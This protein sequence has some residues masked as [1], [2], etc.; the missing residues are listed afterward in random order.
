MLILLSPSKTQ[1]PPVESSIAS[2][3]TPLF[4]KR[5]WRIIRSLRGMEEEDV[6]DMLKVSDSLFDTHLTR[7][8]H[9]NKAHTINNAYPAIE[10]FRGHVYTEFED[11]TYTK[12]QQVYMQK[13]LAILSGLYGIIRPCDL[14]QP[15]RLEMASK[16]QVGKDKNLYHFWSEPVSE[17][18]AST[19]PSFILNCASEE[20]TKVIDREVVDAPWID[21]VF[22]EKEGKGFRQITI[23]TK[24]A[25][26]RLAKWMVDNNITTKEGI[27]SF[28]EDGY[29]F[30]KSHS[31]EHTFT[32][33]R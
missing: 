14:V 9:W 18:I 1:E 26:G 25:R 29:T 8:K 22:L 27:T 19:N 12:K 15:Y 11:A 23:Y 10:L 30:R 20:Y 21:V 3:T 13:N 16:V 31:D 4:E 2:P 6:Q 7:N 17:Y 24:K 28:K 33:V 32:F 5:R